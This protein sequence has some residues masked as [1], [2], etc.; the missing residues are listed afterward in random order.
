ML[1]FVYGFLCGS[2]LM[3]SLAYWIAKK[4]AANV[5]GDVKIAVQDMKSKV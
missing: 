5:A 2:A 3:G 1:N 4:G